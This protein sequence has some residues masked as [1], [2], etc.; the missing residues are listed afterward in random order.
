MH[1]A[2]AWVH[3]QA[4]GWAR[5]LYWRWFVPMGI[6][7]CDRVITV[8]ESTAKDAADLF[9]G[10]G[11]Q[12]GDDSLREEVAWTESILIPQSLRSCRFEAGRFFLCVGFFKDIKNPWRILIRL[13]RYLPGSHGEWRRYPWFALARLWGAAPRRI[14]RGGPRHTGSPAGG[15]GIGLPPWP[16]STEARRL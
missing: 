10:T 12:A 2:F 9:D 13:I 6:R 14:D 7:L 4:V 16:L 5:A 3:P 8:S 15:S 11:G 1:D